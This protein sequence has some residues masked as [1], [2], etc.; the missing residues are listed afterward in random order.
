MRS[1][2]Y[3]YSVFYV[4]LVFQYTMDVFFSAPACRFR[5]QFCPFLF[6]FIDIGG[7]MWRECGGGGWDN[8]RDVVA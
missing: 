5:G 8:V 1:V 7:I 2:V 3:I 6:F 4:E